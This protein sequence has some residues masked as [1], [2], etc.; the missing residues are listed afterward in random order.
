M[1]KIYQASSLIADFQRATFSLWFRIPAA[2][3]G[4]LEPGG[5]LSSTSPLDHM[6]GIELITMGTPDDGDWGYSSISLIKGDFNF[7]R[8]LTLGSPTQNFSIGGDNNSYAIEVQLANFTDSSYAGWNYVT[9]YVGGGEALDIGSSD[10]RRFGHWAGLTDFIFDEWHHLMVS[11]NLTG[12][13]AFSGGF[14]IVSFGNHVPN[15][16]SLTPGRQIEIWFDGV[17]QVGL[18][19]TSADMTTFFTEPDPAK[20]QTN[21]TSPSFNISVSGQQ[22]GISTF[23]FR[24]IQENQ[25]VTYNPVIEYGFID[26]WFGQYIDPAVHLNKFVSEINGVGKPVSRAAAVDAFGDPDLSFSGGASS[27]FKNR[28]TAGDFTKI[29]TLTNFSP[30]PSYLVP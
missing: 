28:G 7:R 14:P 22:I 11:I 19:I 6:G 4:L 15:V 17:R 29:G 20:W 5:I 12:T 30:V 2:Y 8:T 1:A 26:A 13:D 21:A 16:T 23:P 24:S 3:A 18:Y 10:A 9:N 25:I 27:F